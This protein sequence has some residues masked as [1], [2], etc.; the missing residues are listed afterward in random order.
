MLTNKQL[1]LLEFIYESTTASGVSP[2]FEE[3]REALGL[4]SKSGI[5]RLISALEERGFIRRLPHRARALEIIKLPPDWLT[6]RKALKDQ[7]IHE[8][9]QPKNKGEEPNVYSVPLIGNIAAGLPIEAIEDISSHVT[10]PVSMTGPGKHFAL[11][12]K[13]ESMTGEGINHGDIV[14]IRQQNNANNGDIVVAL[15]EDQEATL[16]KLHQKG[17]IIEL[18]AA[19]PNFKTQQFRSDQVKIQGRLVGLLRSY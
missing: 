9:A 2:S 18:E 15:V 3:M 11:E 16:K 10:I 6:N 17:N 14:V 12:V 13:G 1:S 8:L 4:R 5:H 7:D 19:N